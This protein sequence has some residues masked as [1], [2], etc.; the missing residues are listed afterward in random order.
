MIPVR[1]NGRLVGRA[2]PSLCA[3]ATTGALPKTCELWMAAMFTERRGG[4]IT[5]PVPV[6]GDRLAPPRP[7]TMT[8]ACTASRTASVHVAMRGP[9]AS[10]SVRHFSGAGSP[11]S[12][13]AAFIGAIRSCDRGQSDQATLWTVAR[14]D[15]APHG[16]AIIRGRATRSQA[17]VSTGVNSDHHR[18]LVLLF[19]DPYKDSYA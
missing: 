10:K 6:A 3:F 13:E 11:S 19:G 9:W 5:C 17:I 18:R 16:R 8:A 15:R 4:A 7:V 2:V 12:Q 1:T 14:A